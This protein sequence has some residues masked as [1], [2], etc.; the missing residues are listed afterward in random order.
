MKRMTHIAAELREM[1]CMFSQTKLMEDL[2]TVK[3]LFEEGK[4]IFYSDDTAANLAH[5]YK[6]RVP[7]GYESVPVKEV[8]PTYSRL[9]RIE[10]MLEQLMKYLDLATPDP[11]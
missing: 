3:P 9:E 5:L 8:E 11:A 7:K 4:V 1:G 10:K 2:R 6:K